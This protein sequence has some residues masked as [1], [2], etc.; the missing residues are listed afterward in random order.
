MTD[1]TSPN[2]LAATTSAEAAIS[3]DDPL[4]TDL[5]E[6]RPLYG[7]GRNEENTFPLEGSDFESL[8]QGLQQDLSRRP[9][10][11]VTRRL[12]ANQ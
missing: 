2:E 8:V 9:I 4:F 10:T 5:R 11:F 1:S 6:D 3:A 12:A 7:E